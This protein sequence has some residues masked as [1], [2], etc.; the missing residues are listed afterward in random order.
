VLPALI[1]R[2]TLQQLEGA[3]WESLRRKIKIPRRMV[4]RSLLQAFCPF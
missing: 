1:A 3:G 4:Y 2:Q